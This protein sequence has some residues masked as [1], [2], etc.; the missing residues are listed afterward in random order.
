MS[1]SRDTF[2]RAERPGRR[3]PGPE[4][5]PRKIETKIKRKSRL[6]SPS[7]WATGCRAGQGRTNVS[8]R[9]AKKG[10]AIG[11]GVSKKRR[12]TWR[13]A[14][15]SLGLCSRPGHCLSP[16][17]L[18]LS[19]SLGLSLSLS[20]SRAPSTAGRR[21]FRVTSTKNNASDSGSFQRATGHW[22]LATDNGRSAVSHARLAGPLYVFLVARVSFSAPN[23][24]SVSLGRVGRITNVSKKC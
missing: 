7:V 10:E 17:P 13:S 24:V 2:S 19:L 1:G 18:P 20:L 3:T 21:L 8:R 12:F 9:L 5:T 22:Q 6:T 11:D 14:R 4:V 23:L 16:L 15:V